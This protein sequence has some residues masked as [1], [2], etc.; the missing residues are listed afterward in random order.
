[1]LVSGVQQSDSVIHICVSIL[2]QTPFPF[3][4]L[5]NTEQRFLC[6]T[7]GP[8]WLSI[9]Y[10]A[11]WTCQSQAPV[12]RGRRCTGWPALAAPAIPTRP[13][14]RTAGASRPHLADPVPLVH[15]M[16]PA[17]VFDAREH[18]EEPRIRV[19]ELQ[20]TAEN[21]TFKPQDEG[22]GPGDQYSSQPA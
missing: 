1:M 15:E 4:L 19:V 2:F 5:Q 3:R 20:A 17:E 9:L 16:D 11:V 7:V 12:L 13:L 21:D 6:Y 22:K 10:I 18:G 14:Y 8:C